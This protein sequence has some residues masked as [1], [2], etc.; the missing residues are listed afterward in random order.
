MFVR[1]PYTRA[2][3]TSP[4]P[5]YRAIR[6]SSPRPRRLHF[7]RGVLRTVWTRR[8]AAVRS[9]IFL[10]RATVNREIRRRHA[11]Q[12]SARNNR[13]VISVLTTTRADVVL[14]R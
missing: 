11:E 7:A 9:V 12:T 10:F 14:F 8:R 13:F 6:P 2:N 1:L 3:A 5:N 4:S